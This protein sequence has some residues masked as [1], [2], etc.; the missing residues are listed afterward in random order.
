MRSGD[1][2]ANSSASLGISKSWAMRKCTAREI[3][4]KSV[5]CGVCELARPDDRV[6]AVVS[7]LEVI[8]EQAGAAEAVVDECRREAEIVARGEREAA[9]DVLGEHAV[10]DDFEG[11]DRTE[12]LRVRL[13]RR[14]ELEEGVSE[15]GLRL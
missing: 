11:A 2:N 3:Y 12:A 8:L 6:L 9:H 10:A 14:E 5:F 4:Q 15:A 1:K 13:R 7:D